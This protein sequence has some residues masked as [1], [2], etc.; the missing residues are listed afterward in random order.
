M[1]PPRGWS[2]RPSLSSAFSLAGG[3]GDTNA[4]SSAGLRGREKLFTTTGVS[5][6]GGS[7][8]RLMADRVFHPWRAS[9]PPV[10]SG[11]AAVT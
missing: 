8:S 11:A 1:K 2:C 10:P 7:V 4:A 3:E 5:L 6:R 9:P